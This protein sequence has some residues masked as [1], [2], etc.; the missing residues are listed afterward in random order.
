MINIADKISCC[1]CSACASVCPKQC[2][3]MESDD[4][5]FLYPYVD[6]D[7]CVDCG[8][9]EK[10]CNELHPM[11]QRKPLQVL[12]AINKDEEIRLK[13]SSGGVFYE[14]ANKTISDGG[15][16]FGARFDENWQVLI[17]YAED[18]EGVKAFMGS[19][20]VQSRIENAYKD[21]RRF[22]I[23]G[24]KVLFSGTPCQVAGLHQF[25][26]KQFDN[27]LTVDFICH[28]TPS[29]KVWQMYLDEIFGCCKQIKSVSFR[30]K[31]RG[32]LNF[33]FRIEYDDNENAT[34]L[35]SPASQNQY[36]RAFLSDLILRPSCSSCAAKS[37]SSRSD[38]TLADFW[39]IWD[40]NSQMYDNKG[41]SMI[42][43]NTDKGRFV[44]PSEEIVKYDKSDYST[45]LKYNKV[46]ETSV[47]PNSK[48][49]LFFYQLKTT[50]SVTQLIEK[51]LKP[52]FMQLCIINTKLLIKRLMKLKWG[53]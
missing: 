16:V 27:L 2:I 9:C 28:G 23:E 22:L 14:L 21:V 12:A 42:F 3:N 13:S 45:A 41:T 5:G 11:S 1:G 20:Y 25:L 43:I 18:M 30:D 29:P 4:E 24:R 34:M 47:S 50:E 6:N 53:K 32:W 7:T 52:S 15:V 40:E 51:T 38:I 37:G 17:D 35:L 19:K 10:V 44:L 46:C 8:L 33:H 31:T 36:M 26:R 49:D 48:R 39:G